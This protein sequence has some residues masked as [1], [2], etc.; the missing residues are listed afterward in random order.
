MIELKHIRR[1]VVGAPVLL[2]ALFSAA[3]SGEGEAGP[4]AAEGDSAW[5]TR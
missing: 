2:V 3:C 5:P 4:V 1:L